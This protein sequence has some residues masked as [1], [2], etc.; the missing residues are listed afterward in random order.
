MSLFLPKWATPR[1]EA[2]LEEV[3]KGEGNQG[4]VEH[5]CNSSNLGSCGRIV[6]VSSGLGWQVS[7]DLVWLCS[8]VTKALPLEKD[9]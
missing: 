6:P 5:A 8:G 7:G 1:V 3:Y 2:T 4:M 9:N